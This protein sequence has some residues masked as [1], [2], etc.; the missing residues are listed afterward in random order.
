VVI[1]LR[2][3]KT[4]STR[5][6]MIKIREKYYKS[7]IG[8]KTKKVKIQSNKNLLFHFLFQ[9]LQLPLPPSKKRKVKQRSLKFKKKSLPIKN[10]HH[11]Q[12]NRG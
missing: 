2:D 7:E 10:L 12:L 9:L 5:L 11:H 4:I 1:F 6:L 8:F 3:S